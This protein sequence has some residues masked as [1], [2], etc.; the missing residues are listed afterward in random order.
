MYSGK[1]DWRYAANLG[2]AFD[3]EEDAFLGEPVGLVEDDEEALRGFLSGGGREGASAVVADDDAVA[4][5]AAGVVT[6][7]ERDRLDRRGDMDE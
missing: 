2:V 6:W 5:A 1:G 3:V 7:V 4:E